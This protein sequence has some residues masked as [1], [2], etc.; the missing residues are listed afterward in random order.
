MNEHLTEF[1]GLPVAEFASAGA[2]VRAA[3]SEVAWAVREE[4]GFD[5]DLDRFLRSVDTSQVTHLVVGFWGYDGDP[6]EI[7][8]AAGGRLPNLRALFLGDILDQE[9]HISW[10]RLGDLTPLFEAFPGLE[11]LEVRSGE[12]LNPGEEGPLFAPMRNDRLRV[13]RFE[14][15]G[16]PGALVRSVAASDLPALERLDLWLGTRAYGG[17]STLGDLAPVLTGERLPALRDLG[18]RNCDFQDEIAAALASAPVV[19]RLETLGLGMGTLSDRGAESLLSGQPLT[20]LSTLDLEYHH[21]SEPMMERLRAAL[22]GVRVELRMAQGAA[23]WDGEDSW[24]ASMYIAV[25][26]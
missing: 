21:L 16:L 9:L 17:D 15:G 13:L 24:A 12:N 18:L 20:H 8:A 1:A 14:S 7:L 22:P 23:E 25:S 6:V 19:A 2:A 5:R 3:P 4:E 26:E 10:I 11:R